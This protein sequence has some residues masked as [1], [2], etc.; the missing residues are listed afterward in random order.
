MS[1][2]PIPT[3]FPIAAAA[4]IATAAHVTTGCTALEI[5]LGARVPAVKPNRVASSID[6]CAAGLETFA[7]RRRSAA[8]GGACPDAL[9]PAPATASTPDTAAPTPSPRTRGPRNTGGAAGF[10]E[11]EAAAATGGLAGASVDGALGG[12]RAVTTAAVEARL[13]NQPPQTSSRSLRAL[14]DEGAGDRGRTTKL[15]A[16]NTGSHLYRCD[17]WRVR[18]GA[19]AGGTG[20]VTPGVKQEGRNSTERRYRNDAGRQQ[21]SE[22]FAC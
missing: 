8:L 2:K 21:H 1:A 19:R 11:G 15:G 7:R 22:G 3:P 20:L 17:A 10:F 9:A 4:A 18:A 13:T 5:R 16:K 12:E 14:V 6:S